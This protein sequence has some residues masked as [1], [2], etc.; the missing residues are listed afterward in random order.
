MDGIK[1]SFKTAAAPF[2]FTRMPSSYGNYSQCCKHSSSCFRKPQRTICHWF[3]LN[4]VHVIKRGDFQTNA[5]R[6]SLHIAMVKGIMQLLL[7]NPQGNLKVKHKLI[8]QSWKHSDQKEC[9]S[10]MRKV[11]MSDRTLMAHQQNPLRDL[12]IYSY[13]LF[14]QPGHYL[15]CNFPSLHSLLN[16]THCTL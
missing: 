14:L 1:A 3:I 2:S 15:L 12:N 16:P 11:Q 9:I 4:A 8:S 6:F 10:C 13:P 5:H 7:Y